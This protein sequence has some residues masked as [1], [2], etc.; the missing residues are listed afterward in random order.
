M[1]DIKGVIS[2]PWQQHRHYGPYDRPFPSMSQPECIGVCSIDASRNFVDDASGASYLAARPWPSLPIDLNAGI[3]N[4][5]RKP[6]DFAAKDLEFDL[7]YIRQHKDELLRPKKSDPGSLE[8]AADFV[9]LRGILR[10]IMCL[11]Y[12]WNGDFLIKATLLNGTVY[13]AKEDTPEQRLI[14]ENATT[15]QLDMCSWGF[16]FEQYLTSVQPQ[17][18][19]VTNVPVNEAEEFMG[20]FRTNL[21]G[22]RLLY[23]AEMDCVD[24]QEPV[25]FKDPKVLRSLK[26]VE[27]KT[28]SNTKNPKQ[29]RN[30]DRYKSANWW[31][32]SF[33][34]NI[35]TI[36]AGLRDAKG[37]VT[38]IK[39]F[40]VRLLA[41]NKPWNPSAITWF[42]EQFLRNLRALLIAINDPFAVVQVTF[43][44][45]RAY[46]EILRGSEHQ[47][48]PD[49]YRNIFKTK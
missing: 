20:M 6:A 19:P 40:D 25:D 3:E 28:S 46:Y 38:E 30:F 13:M 24:S 42:L 2:L 49:W 4:V 16:K 44:E 27:L 15:A 9:T 23:G 22:L 39:E 34:V 37:Q 47:I 41:R 21:E 17:G 10:K 32:Q 45:K 7:L 31:S 48:L 18:K 36:F 26:F 29:M 11:Q 35:K 8:L 1:V 5:I 12:E 33:L 43:R 14:N